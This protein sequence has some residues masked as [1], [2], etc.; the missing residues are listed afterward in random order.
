MTTWTQAASPASPR[1][2]FSL[3]PP[4]LSVDADNLSIDLD[5]LQDSYALMR[6]AGVNS[7]PSTPAEPLEFRRILTS[8]TPADP[9][10]LDSLIA[11][12]PAVCRY[13]ARIKLTIPLNFG[14]FGSQGAPR[15]RIW[16]A[17]LPPRPEIGASRAAGVGGWG[18]VDAR[19]YSRLPQSPIATASAWSSHSAK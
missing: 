3:Y 8:S 5:C 9:Q 6:E 14:I 15:V 4:F 16:R 11:G 10:R 7:D 19:I 1:L 18:G 13:R 2:D 12:R 17:A